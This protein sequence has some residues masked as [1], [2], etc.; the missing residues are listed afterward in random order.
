MTS[1]A[2]PATGIEKESLQ[3]G[4]YPSPG[5][6]DDF[7]PLFLARKR[8]DRAEIES[9]RGRLTGLRDRGETITLKLCRLD[10]LW[11]IGARDGK[12]LAAVALYEGL[13]RAGK[14]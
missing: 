10:E 6:C 7:I 11:K 12:T 9:M 5:A 4:I 13:Q 3:H 8:L 2:V 14:I 1:L